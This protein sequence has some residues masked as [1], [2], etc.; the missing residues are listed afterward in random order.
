MASTG[1]AWAQ[2]EVEFKAGYFIQAKPGGVGQDTLPYQLVLPANYQ[3]GQK[4]PLM[5]LLHGRGE[6]GSDNQAQLK[7]FLPLINNPVVRKKYPFVYIIPQCPS[8]GLWSRFLDQ[9][10]STKPILNTKPTHALN[11]VRDLTLMVEQKYGTNPQR[12]YLSGLS[13]GGFGTLEMLA[14]YPGIFRAAVPVCAG[15]H[16]A[17]YK[18]VLKTPLWLFH[19]DADAVVK[20]SLSRQLAEAARDLKKPLVYTELPGVKHDSWVATY[21]NPLWL[22]WLWAQ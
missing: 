8:K 1:L 3:P 15:V 18:T 14:Y 12:R 22:D 4:Y 17:Q 5:V 21:S 16:P 20:V 9:R 13:M 2:D 19:G 10:D 11:M 6:R 7:H